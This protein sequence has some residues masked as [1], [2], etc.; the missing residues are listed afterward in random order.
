V[1]EGS[2]DQVQVTFAS[3]LGELGT[4]LAGSSERL[5][6]Q[7]VLPVLKRDAGELGVGPKRLGEQRFLPPSNHS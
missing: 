5:L 7:D 6:D 3:E 4:F 2:G 1:H